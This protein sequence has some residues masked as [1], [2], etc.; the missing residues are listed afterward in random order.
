MQFGQILDHDMMHSPIARGMRPLRYFFQ[1][2]TLCFKSHSVKSF[3]AIFE[4]P[5]NTILNCSSCDSRET[6]SVHCFPIKIG[7]DDPFFPAKHGN[8]YGSTE[9]EAN[10]LRLFRQGKLN[11]TD[12]R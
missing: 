3:A 11:Y 9:C 10:R 4:G 8:V 1:P 7:S 5:N 2:T 12:F 6:L